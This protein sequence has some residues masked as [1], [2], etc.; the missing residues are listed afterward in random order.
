[1][2]C[3]TSS[4]IQLEVFVLLGIR[5]SVP[6]IILPEFATADMFP[7]SISKRS[8]RHASVTQ[9]LH[10]LDRSK[11]TRI[12]EKCVLL[13]Y[14]LCR[15]KEN[16]SAPTQPFT[17][18]HCA[19]CCLRANSLR[20][21]MPAKDLARFQKYLACSHLLIQLHLEPSFFDPH[22]QDTR[23]LTQFG[24]ERICLRCRRCELLYKKSPSAS[25]KQWTV[26]AH[27]ILIVPCFLGLVT[28]NLLQ[29]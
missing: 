16:C 21:K 5:R 28:C 20:G 15:P 1:M 24:G 4:C 27:P 10:V 9:L 12:F 22:V 6:R 13:A 29:S 3:R 19:G 17:A 2:Q 25:I 18:S 7:Q 23:A 8:C 11:R 14:H 26:L